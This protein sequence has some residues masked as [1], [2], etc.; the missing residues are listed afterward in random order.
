MFTLTFS[1]IHINHVVTKLSGDGAVVVRCMLRISLDRPNF[2]S[3]SDWAWIS[4]SKLYCSFFWFCF[5]F[6]FKNSAIQRVGIYDV[7]WFV[8]MK[9]CIPAYVQWDVCM[10]EI[11]IV[12]AM[13]NFRSSKPFNFNKQIFILCWKRTYVVFVKLHTHIL[14]CIYVCMCRH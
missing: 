13:F 3:I 9:C 10:G 5:W 1:T 8:E 11:N 6:C 2:H 14:I 4:Q 12:Y 7:M